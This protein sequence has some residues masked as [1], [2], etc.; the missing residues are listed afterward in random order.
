[1]FGFINLEIGFMNFLCPFSVSISILL[2]SLFRSR[3]SWV[4]CSGRMVFIRFVE[5]GMFAFI[6]FDNRERERELQRIVQICR[7]PIESTT[8]H[9][10]QY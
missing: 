2:H 10:V 3:L 9:H 8:M 4:V 5:D 1:M 6:R 7:C